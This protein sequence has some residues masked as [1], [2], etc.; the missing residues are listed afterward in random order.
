MDVNINFTKKET[1]TVVSPL[2]YSP[3]LIE[4]LQETLDALQEIT[5]SRSLSNPPESLRGK[6]SFI[7]CCLIANKFNATLLDNLT[8][9]YPSALQWVY[10][11]TQYSLKTQL[12]SNSYYFSAHSADSPDLELP[13]T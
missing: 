3:W 1:S 5:T 8:S 12:P 6:S 7:T 9:Q 2:F 11:N 4:G 10:S 13:G